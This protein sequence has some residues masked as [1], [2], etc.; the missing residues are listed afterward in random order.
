MP[1]CRAGGEHG[2]LDRSRGATRGTRF[3]R[4]ALASLGADRVA[5]AH[6]RDDQAETVLLRLVRGA[7][8][9]R[10]GGDAAARAARL[11]RPLLDC[12][13]DG[14]AGSFCAARGEPWREDAT[15]LDLRAFRATASA[16]R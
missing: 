12:T 3:F 6:T 2:V 1:T 5:V 7:G 4:E 10:P 11:V 9:Q 13:R 14:A 16:T 15:N 8:T